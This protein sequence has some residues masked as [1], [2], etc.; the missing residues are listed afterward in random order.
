MALDSYTTLQAA[1]IDHAVRSGDTG[2]EASVPDFITGVEQIVHYGFASGPEAIEPL[3]IA[4][5]ETSATITMT[6]CSGTLPTD[7]LEWRSVSANTSPAKPLT[8]SSIEYGPE[9]YSS[10]TSGIADVFT[11]TGTTIKTYPASS[12]D[13][14]IYYYA[15]LDALSDSNASNWLLEKAPLVYLYGS[16]MLAAPYMMEDGRAASF[17]L[18][19]KSAIQ[20]LVSS[21]KRGRFAR[22]SGRV[23]G[24]TP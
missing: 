14:T 15:K 24:T 7:Y 16:L 3:R 20:G 9:A 10:S 12:A 8:P 4:D 11:I 19:F 17:G 5:M 13:L 21:D 23:R 1:I 6:S 18:L 2:F 22:I